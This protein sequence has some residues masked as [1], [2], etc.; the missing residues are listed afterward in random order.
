M[1]KLS[2]DEAKRRATLDERG[3]DFASA[4]DLFDGVHFTAEDDRKDYGERRYISV[5]DVSGRMCVAVWTPR[6]ATRHIIFISMRKTNDREQKRFKV[7]LEQ[8]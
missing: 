6:R 3:L 4:K 5:G 7:T 1:M 2:W 8:G